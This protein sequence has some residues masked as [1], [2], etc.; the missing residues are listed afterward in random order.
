[1]HPLYYFISVVL[2]YVRCSSLESMAAAAAAAA[3]ASPLLPSS[4]NANANVSARGG[5]W[6][7]TPGH[8]C[9]VCGRLSDDVGPRRGFDYSTHRCG[10]CRCFPS[11]TLS[12]LYI[13][14]PSFR[15]SFLPSYSLSILYIVR[16]SFI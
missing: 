5:D 8:K 14:C 3:A 1:M 12:F 13:V 15:H 7:G 2:F 4:A 10:G 11:Y 16:P 6:S 9:E